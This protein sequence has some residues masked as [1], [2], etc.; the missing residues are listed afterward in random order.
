MKP[1]GI[2]EEVTQ[3]ATMPDI[4]VEPRIAEITMPENLRVGRIVADHR[5]ECQLIECEFDYY[6]FAFGQSPFPVPKPLVRALAANADKGKYA[7]SE[8]IPELR[9]AIAGFNQRHFGLEIDPNR[10]VIGNG[11]KDLINSLFR[12]IQ[13]DVIIPTPAWIGYAPQISLLGKRL[14]LLHLQAESNYR[15]DAEVLDRYLRGLPRQQHILILNNPH[16]PTGAVCSET[17]LRD[18]AEVCRKHRTLILADEIYA[19]TTYDIKRFHSM[20]SI[21]PEGTFVTNG[22]SKDRSAGGY[23]LGYCIVPDSQ[24]EI[25]KQNL[26]KVIA[27]AYTNVSTPI[28]YAAITAYEP[29]E[30]I[31]EYF[32]LTREI[33]RIMGTYF[34][35]RCNSIAGIKAT[36]P[37]STFYFFLDFNELSSDLKREGVMT[38]NDLGKSLITHPFH[39]AAV[40]GDGC[41]LEPD[42]YGARIAFVDYDGEQTLANF[43]QNPPQSES[44]EIEFVQQNAPKMVEG[45]KALEEYVQYINPD[46]S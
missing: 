38:S 19:L 21:Y 42:N 10:V 1:K 13:G 33:H 29:S 2:S 18:I 9:S 34:S 17:E 3:S 11:T 20:A 24:T 37:E 46:L 32:R 7:P 43:K 27:T 45:F 23:R 25:I 28:Q 22:L 40:T 36:I 30:E 4:L 39:F 31:E 41:M 5:K 15:L 26:T 44:G 6:G 8:G 16:N 12:I 14:H 35:E